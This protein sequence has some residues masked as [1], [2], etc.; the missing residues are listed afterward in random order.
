[1][2]QEEE[3]KEKYKESKPKIDV[4]LCDK[5]LSEVSVYLL[6]KLPSF[7][8]APIESLILFL[9]FKENFVD[10]FFHLNTKCGENDS[11]LHLKLMWQCCVAHII[12]SI[13]L[14]FDFDLD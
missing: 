1:M 10:D 9:K 4:L 2:V 5:C 14:R 8:C 13:C 7:F 3:I 6:E 12:F 11:P